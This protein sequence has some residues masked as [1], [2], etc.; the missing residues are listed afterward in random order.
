MTNRRGVATCYLTEA[1]SNSWFRSLGR[2][3]GFAL[4][5]VLHTTLPCCQHDG[6]I[7]LA[8][9]TCM[10]MII[11]SVEKWGEKYS[12]IRVAFQWYM[13]CLSVAAKRQHQWS[14][15][16]QIAAWHITPWVAVTISK[17]PSSYGLY[18]VCQLISRH[19]HTCLFIILRLHSMFLLQFPIQRKRPSQT[20][21]LAQWWVKST[22][23]N[24]VLAFNKACFCVHKLS[25]FSQLQVC[26]F[27]LRRRT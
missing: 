3:C 11:R 9:N 20:P 24:E 8:T 14:L 4:T 15:V 21:I 6:G 12:S 5:H 1:T 17:Q 18:H 25:N 23:F 10:I 16:S 22:H 2:W 26:R 13:S 27:H 19:K 7:F